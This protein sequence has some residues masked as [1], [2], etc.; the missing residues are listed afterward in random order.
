MSFGGE[1]QQLFRA[2]LLQLFGAFLNWLYDCSCFLNETLPLATINATKS[3]LLSLVDQVI[4][5]E[6]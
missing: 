3:S 5:N 1:C 4:L 2:Y 6:G